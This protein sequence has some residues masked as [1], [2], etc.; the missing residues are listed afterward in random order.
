MG[1]KILVSVF[2]TEPTAFEGLAALKALHKSHDITVYATSVIV[3][4]RSGAVAI[5]QTAE[6]GPLGTLLGA[7]TGGLVGLLGG[8]AGAAVGAYL[9]GFGGMT[10]DLFKAGVSMDFVDEVGALLTPGKAAVIADVDE[11]WVAPVNTRLGA[12][13]GT[14]FRRLPGEVIDEQM[15]RESAAAE[16]ELAELKAELKESSDETKAKLKASVDAQKRKLQATSDQIQKRIDETDAE[17]DARLATLHKQQAEAHDRH[18]ARIDAR[19]KELEAAQ[20]ARKAKLTEARRL[21][22]QSVEVASEALV[23]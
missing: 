11:T 12:L 20:A 13:G 1:N 8:P 22:K 5:R 3:K 16:Q 2:D 9:G 7:V 21:A 4:D 6:K 10:Y 23:S 18:R 17:L 15:V 14:T 19:I